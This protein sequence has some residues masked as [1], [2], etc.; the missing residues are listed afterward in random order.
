MVLYLHYLAACQ[1]AASH[2]IFQTCYAEAEVLDPGFPW[3]ATHQNS[4]PVLSRGDDIPFVFLGNLR[5][6]SMVSSLSM[7]MPRSRTLSTGLIVWV[8]R[9]TRLTRCVTLA[10]LFQFPLMEITLRLTTNAQRCDVDHYQLLT[11]AEPDE[12]SLISIQFKPIWWHPFGYVEDT[13]QKA[14]GCRLLVSC[15]VASICL[16]IICISV[17]AD[18]MIRHKLQNMCM[19][20][21][22]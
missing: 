8:R 12:F 7:V 6:A 11:C 2:D 18:T 14:S 15:S 9:S 19:S 20:H 17:N 3:T 16:Q 4:V 5:R 1:I 10:F 21:T 22:A 13:H